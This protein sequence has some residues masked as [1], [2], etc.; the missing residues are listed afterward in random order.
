MEGHA[1]ERRR[2]RKSEVGDIPK[3]KEVEEV[4]R[5]EKVDEVAKSEVHESEAGEPKESSGEVEIRLQNALKELKVQENKEDNISQK[6]EEAIGE[7][8]EMESRKETTESRIKKA[9]DELNESEEG[10]D[11]PKP[12]RVEGVETNEEEQLNEVSQDEIPKFVI[13]IK[14]DI[15]KIRELNSQNQERPSR[16]AIVDEKAYVWTPDDS[17]NNLE[18]TYSEFYY[19]FQDR[20]SFDQYLRDVGNSLEIPTQ[21]QKETENMIHDL[22][23]QMLTEPVDDNCI[24]TRTKRIRGDYV[25][26]MN[27]ISGKT[28]KDIEGDISKVTGQNGQ[29]GIENPRFPHGENREVA[30]ARMAG[31]VMSDCTIEPNGVIKYAESDMTRIKIVVENLNEFG[32]INPNSTYIESENHYITHIPFVMGKMMM[33]RGIPSGDRTIQNP[34]LIRSVREGS[35]RVQ[36]AYTE[37]FITQDGCVGEK[38]VIWRRANALDAGKKSEK[39]DFES[40]VGEKEID[41]IID[42]GRKEKGNAAGWTLSWGKLNELRVSSDDKI[43]STADEFQRIVIENPNKLI[44][45]E[46]DIVRELGIKVEVK[47]SEIKY[48]PE[49]GRVTTIWQA[50]TTGLKETIKLGIT[51]PPNDTVKKEKMKKLIEENSVKTKEALDELRGNSSEFAYWWK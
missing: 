22:A 9:I 17:P 43:A 15:D 32:E 41:L 44:H 49:T 14:Q 46:V 1:Y 47:P 50:Y 18:N 20:E 27:D 38:T 42:E 39:Y 31:T 24:N 16:Y 36:R 11:S 7:L 13:E 8:R 51:S 35:D 34:R 19:Y 37:D 29:G 33:Q 23:S 40:K 5:P 2:K 3:K 21:N 28:L 4:D 30:V 45:D 26:L 12:D 25:H 10:I 48:Y 6:M